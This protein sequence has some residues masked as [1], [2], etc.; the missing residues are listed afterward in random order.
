MLVRI[1][2]FELIRLLFLQF[3][4]FVMLELTLLNTLFE[5]SVHQSFTLVILNGY[6]QHRRFLW[7]SSLLTSTDH[8]EVWI[9]AN[10]EVVH[11]CLSQLK[12][13]EFLFLMLFTD[14]E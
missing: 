9:L 10:L 2:G 8:A 3:F 13:I 14:N 5:W 6:L 1:L 11:A 12:V 7:F 4:L